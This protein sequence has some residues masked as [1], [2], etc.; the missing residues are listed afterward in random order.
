MAFYQHQLTPAQT[1]DL[2]ADLGALSHKYRLSKHDLLEKFRELIR[3]SAPTPVIINT[4]AVPM[5]APQLK[6]EGPGRKGSRWTPEE[7]EVMATSF[8][9]GESCDAIAK[10][11]ERTNTGVASRMALYVSKQA[12]AGSD[13]PILV[14]RFHLTGLNEADMSTFLTYLRNAWDKQVTA[15][16]I[17]ATTGV[18]MEAI[19]TTTSPKRTETPVDDAGVDDPE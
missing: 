19:P 18:T 10:K 2:L 5:P 16:A 12:P 6:V 7:E 4:G 9:S 3:D 13:I 8:K 1:A 15:N 17:A 11:L 14:K